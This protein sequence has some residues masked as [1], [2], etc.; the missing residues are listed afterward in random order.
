[1]DR[2]LYHF[3]LEQI[4]KFRAEFEVRS[5]NLGLLG[6]NYFTHR[7][8]L[9]VELNWYNRIFLITAVI[10]TMHKVKPQVECV[11][12]KNAGPFY[13][14]RDCFTW[15]S[16]QQV[17]LLN[18]IL[19]QNFPKLGDL[20]FSIHFCFKSCK[21]AALTFCQKEQKGIIYKDVYLRSA[22]KEL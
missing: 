5:Q 14:S 16:T 4:N 12:S 17:Q 20:R 13:C 10:T 15:W 9:F 21:W 11:N 19:G 2:H 1:M 6:L 7:K 22:W 18:K 3:I 8:N